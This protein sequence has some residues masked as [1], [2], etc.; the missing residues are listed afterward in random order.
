MRVDRK[1]QPTPA[2][3]NRRPAAPVQRST[4]PAARTLQ[5]RL[6]NHGTQAFIAR[7]V[8]SSPNNLPAKVS[9]PNEAAEV[10]A[11]VAAGKVVRMA[12]P[13]S[14]KPLAATETRKGTV[15]RAEA[16]TPVRVPSTNV[17]IPGGVPLPAPVRT[18]ME[19]RFGANFS[20]VRIH[21]GESAAQQSADLGARAFTVGEHVF[22]G[23]DNFQPQSAG[24]RELIAHELA[25]TIQQGAAVQRSTDPTVAHRSEPRV[26]RFGV[27]DAVDW[28]A[29]KA[30]YIPG[31][32]LLTI[33]LGVNPINWE[34]VDRSAAN[35]LRALL[36]LIPVTGP[37]LAQALDGYGIFAKVG[38]WV[39]TQ[40]RTL[41]LVGNALKGA[42]DKFLDSLSWKDIFH[43]GDVY[44]RGK[45]I[46]TD[47]IDRLL[48]FG[49]SLAKDIL[50]FIREAILLPLA[51]LAEGT[52]GYDLLKAVLGQD[53]VTGQPVPRSP[54]T[55]IGGFM[56]LIGQEEVWENVKKANALPRV[57]AWFQ[58]AL[59]GL[60]AFVRQ[61]PTQ[62]VNA[63]KSL[64]IIDLVFPP[65]AFLKL[66][67]VFGGFV[68]H[69]IS[70]AG[71]TVWNLL[72]IIFDVVSPGALMYIKKTG[73]ALKSILKNP[74]PFVLN[75]VRAAKRGFTNF[76]DHFLTHLKEG[77]IDWLTGSLPDVYIPKAFSLV[78]IAKFAF[79]VLGLTWANIRQKLV[80]AIGET[81]VKA[82]ET[83]FD[84]VVTLVR[85]G[86]AAAWDKIKEQ[87][88]N[89]KDMVIGGITDFVV[90]MVVKKAVP[91]LIS[92]FIPG[93]GFI[94]AILSIY[95]TI[96]VFIDKLAKIAQ[97]VRSFVDSIVSI[98]NGAIDAAAA[99]VENTLAGL[100]SLAINF[101]AGFV[102]L[103][104]VA[105][106][107]RGVIEKIRAPINKALDWLVNWIVTAAKA[108]GKR[109]V[110]A[111]VP[112]DPVARVEQGLEAA[113]KAVNA[114]A[115]KAVGKT[116]L[117]PL[118]AA[119]KVRYAFTTLD[120]IP[121]GTDW[122]VE[123]TAS[124]AKKK[125]T[126]AKVGDG[127]AKKL[128]VDRKTRT[129]GP[130]TV[131]ISMTVDWL[132]EKD[133][134]G[135]TTPESGVHDKLMGLLVTDPSQKSPDKYIR[136][137][138]LNEHLGGR[139]NAENMFPI[140]GNA[141]SQHL[142]STE[143]K[144][145]SWMKKTDRWTFYEVKVKNISYKLDGGPKH[146]ENYVDS[147]FSC[148]AI[149]K[150]QTGKVEEDFST[151]IPSVYTEKGKATKTVNVPGE[152]R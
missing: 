92:L 85:D 68:L 24:G 143:T 103:G 20:N 43:L 33:V 39:E 141:N 27:K 111:G 147:V 69:F 120:V 26:Q 51:K 130:D 102:G 88:A 142:H 89:L 105:E 45:R 2:A 96:K 52:R 98:A 71:N 115:G 67:R 144:V 32:S 53:P 49:K 122:W 93:A 77:L 40:I 73:A 94:S 4:A 19:P 152:T 50:G 136:G 64:E 79:S 66:A 41:G 150:D 65:K 145:K 75:L 91:K 124:P 6:G 25:H 8:Q 13:A 84:I 76:A 87:L 42:L 101:L 86:P 125:K 37:L 104:N 139:G 123:G 118:L 80:A 44:E 70:W 116:L 108:V 109:V 7:A 17:N 129:L 15:Q 59:Q 138:L 106:K 16:A 114:F 83:G 107:V 110:Q 34:H 31:F 11:E 127:A 100:L 126:N 131:G 61:I 57:W 119:I 9:K 97:V 146:P 99:R 137:H 3:I 151:D 12:E 1:L 54:E 47:P 30:R 72:E 14:P 90:D 21:T 148:R 35:I 62:F 74:I 149:L 140:T 46:F 81:A 78:E 38:A 58:G 10:E 112:Q 63:L 121:S 36:E 56:K 29:D 55:L 18:F 117:T 5:E 132:S 128:T 113:V 28:I 134:A 23:R 22:F 133:T 82:L 48:A 135:G 95:D 60:V